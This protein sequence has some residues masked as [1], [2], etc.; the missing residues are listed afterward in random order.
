MEGATNNMETVQGGRDG[1]TSPDS[2]TGTLSESVAVQCMNRVMTQTY[3]FMTD[4]RGQLEVT[5]EELAKEKVDMDELKAHLERTQMRLTT[6]R[7]EC[8][9]LKEEL[10]KTQELCEAL[11]PHKSDWKG[12]KVKVPPYDGTTDWT[13]FL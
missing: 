11:K 5:Q 6:E 13:L 10:A 7:L 8:A 3:R 12:H 1:L 9:M 4:L 2:P